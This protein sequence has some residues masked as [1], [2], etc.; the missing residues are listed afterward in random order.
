[1]KRRSSM[2]LVLCLLASCGGQKQ[3]S[4]QPT[5]SDPMRTIAIQVDRA[6]QGLDAAIDVKRALL[7]D[8]LITQAQSAALTP[9]IL[10]AIRL[11]RELKDTLATVDSFQSG[12]PQLAEVFARV[13]GGFA[14]LSDLGIIPSGQARDKIGNALQI[15]VTALQGLKPLLGGA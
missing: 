9:K 4:T 12:K 10:T 3:V 7:R 15:A 14:A 13:Q 5:T 1:M 2:L 11:V 8:G 6:A